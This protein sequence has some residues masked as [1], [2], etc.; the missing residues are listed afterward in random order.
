LLLYVIFLVKLVEQKYI[1][2]VF[3]LIQ[4]NLIV[5]WGDDD[6]ISQIED[7]TFLV[8]NNFFSFAQ[9]FITISKYNVRF[10]F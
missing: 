5:E 10:D 4:K 3:G 1:V 7:D 2:G 8:K 6:V 9:V